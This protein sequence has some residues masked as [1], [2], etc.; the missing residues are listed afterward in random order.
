MRRRRGVREPK[1]ES[2]AVEVPEGREGV[3]TRFPNT[4]LQPDCDCH[5]QQTK[6]CA[7]RL[8]APGRRT[9]NR[10]EATDFG[11]GCQYRHMQIGVCTE[12]SREPLLPSDRDH[13][14]GG[15]VCT[16]AQSGDGP[17]LRP[18]AAGSGSPEISIL[19]RVATSC[20]FA[21]VELPI[22]RHRRI[23]ARAIRQ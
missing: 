19:R 13:F 14:A 20:S 22:T 9:V 11:K 4:K 21:I 18:V 15:V 23:Q 17:P 12:R 8:G 16:Q 6:H 5:L 2:V 1:V 7:V 10:M 3:S